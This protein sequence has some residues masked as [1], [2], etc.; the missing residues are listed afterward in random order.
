M[1]QSILIFPGGMPRSKHLARICRE[2]GITA[3]GASSLRVDPASAEYDRWIYLPNLGAPDFAGALASSVEEY[4]F[5]AIY[6]PHPVIWQYLSAELPSLAPGVRLVQPAPMVAAARPYSE[7]EEKAVSYRRRPMPLGLES[8]P[9]IPERELV[10][11]LLHA[12]NIPGMCHPDK[13][14]AMAEIAAAS[15]AGDLVEIGTWWGKSAF[16]M[17]R[18]GRLYGIGPLLCVDPWSQN[19]LCQHDPN[20][21]LNAMAATLDAGQ[22]FSIFLANLLPYA[23][24]DLNYLRLP[25]TEAA[26]R[27][28]SN[29]QVVSNEFGETGY[30]GRI[31]ILHIDGNHEEESVAADLNAWEPMMADGGWIVFDDYCWPF[32]DGPRR[33]ADAFLS[34]GR[35]RV[36]TSFVAGGALF[37]KLSGMPGEV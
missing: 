5:H 10:A 30:C 8:R 15:P 21:N 37:V 6:T 31:A 17:L 36:E 16:V 20:G 29:H 35:T 23:D 27:F 14:F 1:S 4:G 28:E 22:A 19:C 32:G 2:I 7:A 11:M 26:A 13:L 25:S 18:L 3:T 34:A 33:V 9:P 12:E 24:G